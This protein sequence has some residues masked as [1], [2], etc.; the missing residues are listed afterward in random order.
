MKVMLWYKTEKRRLRRNPGT[1]LFT[2]RVSTHLFFIVFR[3]TMNRFRNLFIV[4]KC[5]TDKCTGLKY[6]LV[7]DYYLFV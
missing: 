5:I 2:V 7:G 6:E 4:K 3:T 1:A